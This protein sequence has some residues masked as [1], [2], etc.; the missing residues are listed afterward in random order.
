MNF[1]L[2]QQGDLLLIKL[3]DRSSKT[4]LR[5]IESGTGTI[6][7]YGDREMVQHYRDISRYGGGDAMTEAIKESRELAHGVQR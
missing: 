7:L 5:S 1:E 6:D 4:L 3:V 2:R